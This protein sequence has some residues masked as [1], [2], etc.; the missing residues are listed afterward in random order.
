MHTGYNINGMPS[1]V[2]MYVKEMNDKNVSRVTQA[3][4]F[5]DR[6]NGNLLWKCYAF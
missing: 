4:E 1:L 2:E 5:G 3:I 6:L